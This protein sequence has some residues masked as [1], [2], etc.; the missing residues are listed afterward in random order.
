M[1]EEAA[2]KESVNVRENPDPLGALPDPKICRT[3]CTGG[4]PVAECLVKSPQRCPFVQQFGG[5]LYCC[6]PNRFKFNEERG[7]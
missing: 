3:R 7:Q 2:Q 5:R 4:A 6:H 1:S